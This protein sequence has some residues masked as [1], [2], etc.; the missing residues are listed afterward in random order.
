M[1]PKILGGDTGDTVFNSFDMDNSDNMVI[2]GHSS[3][4][5]I[6]ST[7]S[8]SR[9][10]L[11]LFSS[12]SGSYTWSS[13]FTGSFDSINAVKFH[14]AYASIICVFDK[15]PLTVAVIKSSDGTIMSSFIDPSS[16][17]VSTYSN[18]IS[19]GI[20]YSP[21]GYFHLAIQSYDAK[22]QAMRFSGAAASSVTPVWNYK[23]S[24][25]GAAY[26]FS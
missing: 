13:Y 24:T 25:T 20:D 8:V 9:P 17:S 23:T 26:A 14:T 16:G 12:T 2:G 6:V 5:G 1:Y 15:F 7:T 18:V 10:L 3:D 21:A 22:W 4:S 11:V 19:S